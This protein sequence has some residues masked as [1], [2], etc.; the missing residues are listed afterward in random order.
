M[1]NITKLVLMRHGESQWNQENKFTGWVDIDLSNKGRIEAEHASKILRDNN[2]IFDY[3]YTSMLKR[4]IRTLWIVLDRLNQM[5]LP[6]EKSWNLNER[7]YGI[8]Q[9]LNKDE[10]VKKYGYEKIKKWRRSFNAIPPPLFTT[11]KYDDY[12]Y[13][14]TQ[15][16]RYKDIH[17]NLLPNGESLE[18]TMKR[19]ISYWNTTIIPHIKNKKV[20]IIVAH[21]NSIRAIIKFLNNLNSSEISKT[22][23]P[24]GSPLIY[25]FDNNANPI[26]H[27]YL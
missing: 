1:N 15:D 26:K 13:N 2:F 7:H 24:T 4:A 12:Q 6:I 20:L 23:V 17:P 25:E 14:G 22:N 27:Y 8:L 11:T 19:V 21:G 18:E 3:G 9:G 5:W 10:A 16:I